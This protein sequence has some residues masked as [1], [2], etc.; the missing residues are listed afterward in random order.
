MKARVRFEAWGQSM[1]SRGFP[2]WLVK[3]VTNF[4]SLPAFAQEAIA[5]GHMLQGSAHE[6][7]K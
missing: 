1:R 2:W 3:K 4:Y 7:N 6:S 5:R